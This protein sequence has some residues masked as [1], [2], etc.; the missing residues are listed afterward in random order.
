MWPLWKFPLT[1]AWGQYL[2]VENHWTK[3]ILREKRL[4]RLQSIITQKLRQEEFE[5]LER[6]RETMKALMFAYSQ[7]PLYNYVVQELLPRAHCHPVWTGFSHVSYHHQD[8]PSQWCSIT[9]PRQLHDET[10]FPNIVCCEKLI[11]KKN[12]HIYWQTILSST[13][14][15]KGGICLSITRLVYLTWGFLVTLF[16]QLMA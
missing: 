11:S 12:N 5:R 14:K 2:K 10:F 9:W 6:S 1:P 8:N 16:L 7:H 3:A 15:G 4:F 13:N